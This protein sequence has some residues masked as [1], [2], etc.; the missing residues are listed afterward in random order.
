MDTARQKLSE[1]NMNP[2]RIDEFLETLNQCEYVRF[3]PSADITPEK[4]Y[5]KT[6]AFITRMEQELKNL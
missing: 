3:A 2:E 6:F 1:R 4:M 5:E